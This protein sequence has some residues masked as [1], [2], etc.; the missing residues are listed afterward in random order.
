MPTIHRRFLAESHYLSLYAQLVGYG[1]RKHATYWGAAAAGA[2]TNTVFGVLRAYV[3][4]ALWRARPG[5]GGYDVTDAVTF[6]FLTQAYIGPMQVFGGGLEITQRIRTGD[7][8]LDLVRPAPLIFWSL[9]EDLGR[10]GYLF[11]AR[12]LPPTVVGALLFGIT[13]PSDAAVWPAFAVSFA[14]GVVISFGW[15]YIVALAICWLRDDRGIAVMSLVLTTFFSGLMLPLTIF[16]GRLG[17]L[18]R[19][20]PWSAMVQVPADVFLG[21]AGI[22]GALGFQALWAAVLLAL[23]A[24]LTRAARRKV[25]VDGG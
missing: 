20:L 14:L 5:L 25:V 19:A 12:S 8:A 23:G 1:F 6:C 17:T 18:A 16:P 4:I 15:R 3:L 2:F 9:S 13:F 10:A 24:L 21:K 7:I 22:P 11:L